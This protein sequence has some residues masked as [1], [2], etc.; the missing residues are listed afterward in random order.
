MRLRFADLF[1][2][3]GGF[4][5]ALSSLGHECAFA[6]EIDAE[7][8]DLYFAN[9]RTMPAAD[10]RSLRARDLPPFDVLCAGFPC[11]PFSKAGRQKGL[12]DPFL[13]DLIW[14][15]AD[16][17]RAIKPRYMILEN[18]PNLLRHA[19]GVTWRAIFRELRHAGYHV[20][21]RVL[22]PHQFGVPQIRERLY[23]IASRSALDQ[24]A[25][26]RPSDSCPALRELLDAKPPEARGLSTKVESAIDAWQKF[27]E[28]FR[29][30]LKKPSFPIW[31]MEFGATYPFQTTTPW[32]IGL[33]S[34]QGFRGSL[35]LSL[36][37][38]QT[39]D[40]ALGRVP[41]YARTRVDRFPRWKMAFIEQN[42]DLY[43]SQRAWIE[44]WKES[45]LSLES[46][47]QKLEWNFFE[48]KPNLWETVIQLRAS[49][50]RARPPE[51]VPSLVSLTESQVP[52]IAWERRYLTVRECARLQHLESLMHLPKRSA[53]AFQALGNAV[54][55]K[56]VQLIAV[57]LFRSRLSVQKVN[58]RRL[59]SVCTEVFV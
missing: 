53:V 11:Q 10:I 56:V 24:F 47:Y 58:A 37:G 5:V 7:L 43:D 38:A 36:Q 33:E 54:N 1:S 17:A 50:I 18:V 34:L 42:R 21:C 23:I 39:I 25:W 45:L 15:I 9:F 49:G 30:P 14:T 4:N 59:T 2:G 55:S 12:S 48:E 3:L 51:A 16:I 44:P 28:Q 19:N 8:R 26:P 22:S 31:G 35:G 20:D 13:G 27:V 52:I 41:P 46:S 29:N 6:C 32:S 40:D 57:N